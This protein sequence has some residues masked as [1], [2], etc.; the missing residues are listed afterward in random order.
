[1]TRMR[2]NPVFAQ[3]RPGS[4][5]KNALVVPARAVQEVLPVKPAVCQADLRQ[6]G[7]DARI[8]LA[9]KRRLCLRLRG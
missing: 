2:T 3:V 5:P 6:T 7:F 9:G 4:L 8:R 1:M